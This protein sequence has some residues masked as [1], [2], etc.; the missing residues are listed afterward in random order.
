MRLFSTMMFLKNINKAN[1]DV[2]ISFR[3]H[4][5]VFLTRDLVDFFVQSANEMVSKWHVS[6]N[7]QHHQK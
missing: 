2:K 7:T 3:C 5:L 6:N 4:T 1:Y